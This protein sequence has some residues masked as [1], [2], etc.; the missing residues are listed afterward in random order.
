MSA[1]QGAALAEA[2]RDGDFGLV[3][4]VGYLRFA[5]AR[6]VVFERQ[7]LFRIVQ[8]KASQ[9]IGVG[10]FAELAQLFFV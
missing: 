9:A 1:K 3:E 2:A 5:E 8:P 10:K 7:L 6:S 4:S